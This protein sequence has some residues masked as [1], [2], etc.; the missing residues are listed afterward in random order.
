MAMQKVTMNSLCKMCYILPMTIYLPYS[1]QH[2]FFGAS[3]WSPILN[4][5]YGTSLYRFD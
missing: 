3:A 4:K 2:R 1:R 5:P